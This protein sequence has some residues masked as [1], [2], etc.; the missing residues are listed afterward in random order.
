MAEEQNLI[1]KE[2]EDNQHT[3][4]RLKTVLTETG[5][6][7]SL[8]IVDLEQIRGTLYTL[9]LSDAEMPDD[10]YFVFRDLETLFDSCF[11]K[12]ENYEVKN[13]GNL[14]IKFRIKLADV[15]IPK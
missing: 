15:T 12:R 2:A 14:L 13:D 9:S 11:A 6:N 10:L 3:N 4:Y 1:L 7:I 8:V 5:L